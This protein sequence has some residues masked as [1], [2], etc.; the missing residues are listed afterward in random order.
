MLLQI[1]YLKAKLVLDYYHVLIQKYCNH[2]PFYCQSEMF[3]RE[4]I[5]ISRSKISSW[6]GQSAKLLELLVDEIKKYILSSTHIHTDDTPIKVLAPGL[7]RTRIGRHAYVKDSRPHGDKEALAI[8][9]YYSPDRKG[10]RPEEHLENYQ[11]F[12]HPD[13]YGGYDRLYPNEDNPDS[14]ISDIYKIEARIKGCDPGKRLKERGVFNKL[15][16]EVK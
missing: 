8:C 9:Y 3:T 2:L 7:G 10:A 14:K 11:G 5:N 4:R 16:Q 1:L 12:L 6:T 15:C 13:A